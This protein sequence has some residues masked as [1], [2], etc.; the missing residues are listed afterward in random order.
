M[1][2][3]ILK[4]GSIFIL[5][6][7]WLAHPLSVWA[8]IVPDATL[9]SNSLVNLEGQ[10]Q[11]ITG[12]T[13]AGENLFHSFEQFNVR[14]GETA[15]FDNATSIHNIITRVTGGQLSNI[16]G[17]IRANGSANLFL[18]NPGGIVFGPNARLDIGGS[19]L[20]STA[21][22]LLFADGIA[23]SATEPQA[24][25][26]LSINIPIG[27]QFG[28]NPGSIINRSQATRVRTDGKETVVGLQVLPEQTLALVGGEVRLEGG[29]LTS[30]AGSID[31]GNVGATLIDNQ[32]NPID[33][34]QAAGGRIEVGAV[35]ANSQVQIVQQPENPQSLSL[36]YQGVNTFQNIQLSRL[37][38]IDASGDG[39][40]PIQI[41][42]RHVTVSEGSQIRSNT[43]G[44]NPGGTVV[45][46]G[47]ESVELVGNNLTNGPL[48]ARLAAAGILIPRKTNLSTTSFAQ[49]AAGNIIID[50]R[51][52]SISQGAEI[53]AFSF[54]T[55]SEAGRGGDILIRASDSVEVVGLA[56][57][58]AYQPE[59]FFPFGFDVPGFDSPFWREIAFISAISS[60]SVGDG[61]AGNVSIDTDRLIVSEGGIIGANAFFSGDGGTMQ[62]DASE[63]V[64]IYGTSPSGISRS[65]LFSSTTGTGN[66]V[67]ILV[68]TDRLIVRDGGV[69]QI[70]AFT[71]GNAGNISIDAFESVEVGG[72]TPDGRFASNLS[73]STFGEG[74]AG[75]LTVNTPQFIVRDS[76]LAEVNS[77]RTGNAGN[78]N[79]VANSLRLDNGA[80]LNAATVS[81]VGGNLTLRT[82]DLQL[83]R[84]SSLN[85][86]AGSANGGNISIDT[87]TLVALE[88]SDISANAIQGSG[89]QVNITA[90]GIFGTAFRDRLTPES[91]ITATS[92][93]GTEFSGTVT[94][95]TPDID[96]S[97]G[98][99][100]LQGKTTDTGDR[101][102]SG[103]GA[104]E[105]NSFTITGRGGLPE[106]P[107][108]TLRSEMMWEDLRDLIEYPESTEEWVQTPPP[109]EPEP[110]GELVEATGW[111]V[112][113]DGT[114]ELVAS[115]D[116][117]TPRFT[118]TPPCNELSHV[119][120][121]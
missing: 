47:A 37:A 111:I 101:I 84:G 121:F 24:T 40:G 5:I 115:R 19:F 108:E 86:N 78:L 1:K 10:I 20:G 38:V 14:T 79:V 113:D 41:Q 34:A 25:P 102:V 53:V 91:D 27:L 58:I 59:L 63:S 64:E 82:S 117:S 75:N 95:T 7:G 15:F 2:K 16:D 71:T 55:G 89:G 119:Y 65:A 66:A 92:E 35:V 52:L 87:E 8:Q 94:L 6:G 85:T 74:N 9:P 68:K 96:A 83:R 104:A 60:S 120:P 112:R 109:I 22:S 13:Q 81:G 26:L 77:T 21:D 70:N 105:G 3:T 93:L 56:P 44:N 61:R 114:V 18:L 57:L 72:T 97:A 4:Q 48:E 76:A 54:G 39:G 32:G 49:G 50:T 80:T 99:V 62:I 51:R 28:S 116:R 30:A 100:E 90:Q 36:N 31:L 110:T 29:Y 67:G 98:L 88:N 33:V 73:A 42:G 69:I 118:R 107:I 106:S 23:F 17:I 46:R 43:L 103:C 11:Q 45:V 12:G